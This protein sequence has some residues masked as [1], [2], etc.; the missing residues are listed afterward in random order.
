MKT[1]ASQSSSLSG[2]SPEGCEPD[3]LRRGLLSAVLTTAG[4]ALVGCQKGP[5][6]TII[7]APGPPPDI[8]VG[9]LTDLLASPGLHW[10]VLAEPEK[11][12]NLAWLKPSLA[13]VLRDERLE[14]LATATGLD[15]RRLP[16]LALAGYAEET[17]FLLV[18]HRSDPLQMERKFRQRLT[19]D[20][21]RSVHRERLVR[22]SGKIGRQVRVFDAVGSEVVGY[23]YGGKPSRGPGR[24]ALL[25]AGGKLRRAVSVSADR[26]V[27]DS[28]DE[29][30]AAAAKVVLP[31]PFE[32]RLA[33]G[34][35]GLLGAAYGLAAGISPTERQSLG[36]DVL[37]SGDYSVDYEGATKTLH[38]AWKDLATSD[39]GHLL[40]FHKPVSQPA[41]SHTADRLRLRAELDPQSLFDGLAAATT[42]S[43]AEI[44]R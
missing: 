24:I 23:Q 12:V 33:Q 10:L 19:S 29:L 43:V 42:D 41:V 28:I 6:S 18:R 31:G 7:R 25:L 20:E 17:V 39:L 22:A 34:A 40:G 32:G 4:A 36:L 3:R 8:K 5:T 21:L 1:R 2:Y 37:V 27:A 15:L 13:R 44:M 26:T 14:L 38:A 35:R 16:N 30:G 9:A 11:L